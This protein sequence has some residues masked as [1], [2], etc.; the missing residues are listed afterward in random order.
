MYIMW[1]LR[2]KGGGVKIKIL[3]FLCFNIPLSPANVRS[4]ASYR[5]EKALSA[6]EKRCPEIGGFSMNLYGKN[7]KIFTFRNSKI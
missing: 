2:P 3:D 7:C 1:G 5:I 4:D 6:P